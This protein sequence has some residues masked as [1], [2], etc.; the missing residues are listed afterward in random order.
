[1]IISSE[2]I[3]L[4]A[5]KYG[6]TSRIVT[7][8]TRQHGKVTTIA[9][10]ARG[11]KSK[12]SPAAL[13]PMSISFITYYMKET[14]DI[15]ILS[16]ADLTAQCNGTIDNPE[17]LAPGFAIIETMNA[18]LHGEE[19]HIV[20]YEILE[21]ALLR[22]NAAEKNPLSV[23]FRFL[24]DLSAAL[25]FAI[26]FDHCAHCRADFNEEENAGRRVAFDPLN[27]GFFCAVCTGDRRDAISGETFRVL[28]WLGKCSPESMGS[29][30]YSQAASDQAL[31]TL[32]RHL[33]AHVPDMKPLRS[34]SMLG[35]YS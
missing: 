8:Y 14:R 12:F 4:R 22:L 29:L 33:A 17:K 9:K 31:R 23:Y 13:Q 7:F 5:I 30:S 34:L 18:V 19:Q 10:G 16:N 35:V 6:D 28:K 11:P 32:S 27:G 20:L 1:M 15:Q 2:A 26:D 21:A 3:V 24:L 25:G